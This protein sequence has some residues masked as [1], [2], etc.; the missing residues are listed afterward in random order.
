MGTQIIWLFLISFISLIAGLV[1]PSLIGNFLNKNLSRKRIFGYLGSLTVLLFIL[2]GVTNPTS[3]QV[4]SDKEVKGITTAQ[5]SS[6]ATPSPSIAPSPT[7][8]SSLVPSPTATAKPTPTVTPKPVATSTPVPTTAPSV[9]SSSGATAI[10]RDGTY[11]Y[12]QHRSGTCSHHGGVAQ[13]L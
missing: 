11:S 10:C 2:V 7:L 5:P 4:A 8:S 3:T 1:K 9:N 12:S 13:W 6:T